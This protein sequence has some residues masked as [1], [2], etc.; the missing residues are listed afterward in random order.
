VVD[1]VSAGSDAAELG[2]QLR[3]IGDGL[4]AVTLECARRELV[5]LGLRQMGKNCVSG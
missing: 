4:L 2:V 5:D 3:R 1:G